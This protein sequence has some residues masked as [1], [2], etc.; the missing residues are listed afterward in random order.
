MGL[1]VKMT[2]ENKAIPQADFEKMVH[3]AHEKVCP[4]S[5]ATRDNVPVTLEIIGGLASHLPRE[6]SPGRLEKRTSKRSAL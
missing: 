6:P 5:H 1:T 3:E 2:V 4:Y